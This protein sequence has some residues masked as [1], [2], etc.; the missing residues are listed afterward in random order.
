MV[1]EAM[2]ASELYGRSLAGDPPPSFEFD[3]KK[4]VKVD[5]AVIPTDVQP[6]L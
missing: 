6:S 5:I 2:P 4:E 3:P 1:G